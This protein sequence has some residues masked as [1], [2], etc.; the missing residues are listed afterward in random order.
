MNRLE[1]NHH[2]PD[3]ANKYHLNCAE[4]EKNPSSI[5][6]ISE[7]IIKNKGDVTVLESIIN[8]TNITSKQKHIVV[9]IGKIN[10]T[11]EHEFMIGKFL[12]KHNLPGFIRYMC[13]FKCYD[14]IYQKIEMN[15]IKSLS[16]SLCNAEKEDENRKAILVMPFISEGSLR[17][18]KWN[19]DKYNTLKSIL[20]QA[21]LSLFVAYDKY[22]FLHNDLH[23]DNIL[24]KKTKKETI[25]YELESNCEI[26]AYGYKLVIMDF[27]NSRINTDHSIGNQTYWQNL[28]NMFS[29]LNFD[30]KNKD[31][32]TI[33]L[34]NLNDMTGFII[35][36][37]NIKGSHRNSL[38]L[39]DMITKSKFKIIETQQ[40]MAYNPNIF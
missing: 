37:L 27:E 39:L 29:R 15:N 24:L 4:L 20:Q 7:K 35:K 31:N 21:I 36:Q 22:G 34:D 2:K 23:L 18:F 14:D 6:I 25:R 11:I 38:K 8:D 3:G 17:T 40:V 10:K 13:L 26:K 32:N 1:R 5:P 28:L 30:I 9:K 19:P 12:E 33:H 16:L